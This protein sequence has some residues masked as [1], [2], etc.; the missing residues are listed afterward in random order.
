MAVGEVLAS[1]LGLGRSYCVALGSRSDSQAEL[2]GY[3]GEKAEG[4]R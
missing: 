3:T 1:S 2:L 4:C